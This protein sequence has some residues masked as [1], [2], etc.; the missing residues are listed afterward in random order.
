MEMHYAT[1]LEAISDAL[2]TEEALVFGDRRL[3]WREL[4]QRAARLA[5]VMLEAG[6][7]PGDRIGLF[8]YN[9]AEYMEAMLAA[10]KIRAVPININFRYTGAELRYLI[11]LR[12][13]RRPALVLNVD[14]RD[15]SYAY[16]G[17]EHPA[18]GF[19]WAFQVGRRF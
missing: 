2:T 3:S 7:A 14:G 17:I 19:S 11:S 18:R 1:I 9:C 6:V 4:D 5:T 12:F 8:L 15:V 13:R 16:R 10:M